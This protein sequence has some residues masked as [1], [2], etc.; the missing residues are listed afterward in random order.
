MQFV[1]CI[2]HKRAQRPDRFLH[3]LRHLVE[4]AAER[5][6]L[7]LASHVR[8][9]REVALRHARRDAC[10]PGERSNDPSADAPTRQGG[11]QDRSNARKDPAIHHI[12]QDF[13]AIGRS[14]RKNDCAKQ[15]PI[16]IYDQLL[17]DL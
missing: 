15:I 6:D 1:G 9:R 14:I 3:A 10:Q 17:N 7:I 2:R 12:V 8:A 11:Q 16:R 13:I 5:P 4:R